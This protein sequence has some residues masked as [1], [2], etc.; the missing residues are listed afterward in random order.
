M[1]AVF[2]GGDG[3]LFPGYDVS[4]WQLFCKSARIMITKGAKGSIMSYIIVVE[5]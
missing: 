4:G 1:R 5:V 3:F 2:S